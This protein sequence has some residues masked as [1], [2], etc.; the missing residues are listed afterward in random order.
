M[1]FHYF[2]VKITLFGVQLHSFGMIFTLFLVN[3]I[4][5][6]LFTL[7]HLESIG[8]SNIRYK[9]V[10]YI[11]MAWPLQPRFQFTSLEL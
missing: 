6:V 1:K 9:L 11:L 8:N 7:L 4:S 3:G 2:G 10:S 5:L